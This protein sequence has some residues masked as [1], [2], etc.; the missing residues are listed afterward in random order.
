MLTSVDEASDQTTFFSDVTSNAPACEASAAPFAHVPTTRLPFG[1]S[2]SAV[3]FAALRS[4]K[5]SGFSVQQAV[6]S[7]L[8][9]VRP[10]TCETTVLPFGRR[11]ASNTNAG[12]FTDHTTCPA[13]SNSRTVSAPAQATR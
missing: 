5:S 1:R 13:R 10:V 11:T 9:S 6:P 4:G 3:K 12:A 7:G 8:Y 2:W